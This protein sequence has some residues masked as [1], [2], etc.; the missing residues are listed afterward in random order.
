MGQNHFLLTSSRPFFARRIPDTSFIEIGGGENEMEH[1]I[2]FSSC[3]ANMC[4]SCVFY[5]TGLRISAT[6]FGCLKP[7]FNDSSGFFPLLLQGRGGRKKEKLVTNF[8]KCTAARRFRPARLLLLCLSSPSPFS[9]VPQ[10]SCPKKSTHEGRGKG[11][12]KVKVLSP[13]LLF[14]SSQAGIKREREGQLSHGTH[15]RSRST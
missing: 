14:C 10:L 11:G 7:I 5:E 6:I 13:F 15:A 3:L 1:P 4:S 8:Q 9:K 2:L 12:A